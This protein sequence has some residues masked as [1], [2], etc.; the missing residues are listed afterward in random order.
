MYI[1]PISIKLQNKA[2]TNIQSQKIKQKGQ[3]I[4]LNKNFVSLLS[5]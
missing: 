4:N 1:G 5:V 2:E 3:L